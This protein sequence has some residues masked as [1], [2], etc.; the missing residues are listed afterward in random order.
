MDII[1]ND[2]VKIITGK[3]KGYKAF[4]TRVEN[5]MACIVINGVWDHGIWY[6]VTDLKR[7]KRYKSEQENKKVG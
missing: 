7:T 6:D 3:Y 1:K 4:V 5:D 2:R